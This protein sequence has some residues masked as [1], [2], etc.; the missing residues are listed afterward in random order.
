MLFVMFTDIDASSAL[1]AYI[2]RPDDG[3]VLELLHGVF[4]S[5]NNA[6]G[7]DYASSY[8][9]RTSIRSFGSFFNMVGNMFCMVTPHYDPAAFSSTAG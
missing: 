3:A 8:D 4:H 2:L 9:E 1:K 6:L 5:G 7:T